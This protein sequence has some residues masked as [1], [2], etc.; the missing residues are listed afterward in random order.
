MRNITLSADADMIDVARQRAESENTTLNAEFRRWLATYARRHQ[1]GR[2]IST[3]RELQAR[4][5]TGGR[6]FTRD[7]MNER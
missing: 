7:E 2:A 5:T 3:V 4:Y 1:A 6:K